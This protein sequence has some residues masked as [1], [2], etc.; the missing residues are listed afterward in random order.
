M[1]KRVATLVVFPRKSRGSIGA[2]HESRFALRARILHCGL[3]SGIVMI[4]YKSASGIALRASRGA[5]R[6]VGT[7][8]FIADWAS[9][10]SQPLG[11]LGRTQR[12]FYNFNQRFVLMFVLRFDLCFECILMHI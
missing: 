10:R 9:E 5:K 11:D 3:Y 6:E 12:L 2:R 8:R 1:S 7:P 4:L